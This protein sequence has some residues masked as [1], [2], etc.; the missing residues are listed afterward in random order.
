MADM[1]TVWFAGL[2]VDVHVTAAQSGGHLGVWESW[3]PRGTALPPHVHS[4]ED[5]QI[6]LL[7]GEARIRLGAETHVLTTGDTLALPRD[8][9]HAHEVLSETAHILTVA[10]PGGFEQLFLD[11]GTTQSA[12][13]PPREVFADA[14]RALGVR[15]LPR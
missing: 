12:P 15:Q 9:P 13:I 2:R 3:E 1:T 7:E 5:E 4:R 10:T 6:V 8:V 14:V 11:L